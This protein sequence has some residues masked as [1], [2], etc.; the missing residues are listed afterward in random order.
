MDFN[1]HQNYPNPFNPITQINYELK[2]QIHTKIIVYNSLGEEVNI[3]VNETKNAGNHTVEWD[4]RDSHN[5]VLPSGI[6]L[7]SL[8]TEKNTASIKAILLK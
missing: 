2:K 7:I 5:N 1:L 4:G 3:L 6:Y 8:I